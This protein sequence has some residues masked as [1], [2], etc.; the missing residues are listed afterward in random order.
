MGTGEPTTRPSGSVSWDNRTVI[1]TD[2]MC[3][4]TSVL[5]F[6]PRMVKDRPQKDAKTMLV[7]VYVLVATA[8][9]IT[10]ICGGEIATKVS[11]CEA[12]DL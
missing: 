4:L 2:G 11:S 6:G 8:S 5:L 7:L 1:L 9:D 10:N 12:K 3:H